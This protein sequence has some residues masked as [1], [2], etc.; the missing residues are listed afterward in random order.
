MSFFSAGT[1]TWI[2]NFRSSWQDKGQIKITFQVEI[3]LT[4]AINCA[5]WPTQ[6]KMQISHWLRW[7]GQV[8]GYD[9]FMKVSVA[10]R[11]KI[12][13]CFLS[14]STTWVL[15]C[16]QF[17]WLLQK[18]RRGWRRGSFIGIIMLPRTWHCSVVIGLASHCADRLQTHHSSPLC[19]ISVDSGFNGTQRTMTERGSRRSGGGKGRKPLSALWCPYGY[20]LCKGHCAQSHTDTHTHIVHM[21]WQTVQNWEMFVH[22]KIL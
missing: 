4:M 5:A 15:S 19:C 13:P 7:E 10:A 12:K 14:Q 9:A 21:Q 11:Y 8:G 16:P 17:L 3:Q 22:G 18:G 20:L 2:G 1:T 6:K